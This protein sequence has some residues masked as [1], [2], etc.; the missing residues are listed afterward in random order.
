MPCGLQA[1][2]M[3]FPFGQAH[4]HASHSASQESSAGQ[5]TNVT[6][7]RCGSSSLTSADLQ[8]FLASRLQ[9]SPPLNGLMMYS[10]GWKMQV[11]PAQRQIC[12][13]LASARRI[14]GSGSTGLA[15]WPT[16]SATDHKG[17]YY[18]GR[19][20]NGK[21]STDRLDV[22]AQLATVYIVTARGE[23]QTVSFAATG[24]GD[25]FRLNPS[26]SR[27]LQGYPQEWGNCAPTET[28]SSRRPLRNL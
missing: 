23:M 27:W 18:G 9:A 25:R 5:P 14:S 16:P 4:A 17:G 1:C 15:L 8:S 26:F 6:S 2:Q 10:M 12:A 7:G 19:K 13:L 24:N 11:T 3:M 20:R 28:P 21:W 22:T